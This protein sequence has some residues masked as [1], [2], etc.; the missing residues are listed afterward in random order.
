MFS[1]CL[2]YSRGLSRS[3]LDHHPLPEEADDNHTPQRYL[4]DLQEAVS[5]HNR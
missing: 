4:H 2:L 3:S 5:A 1:I